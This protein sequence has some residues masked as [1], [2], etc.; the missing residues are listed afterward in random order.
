MALAS[1]HYAV[2]IT[3]S[4]SVHGIALRLALLL[5]LHLSPS[6]SFPQYLFLFLPFSL[7]P[8]RYYTKVSSP[9]SVPT[10]AVVTN[11][12]WQ[13][14]P[15]VVVC[16]YTYEESLLITTPR[17]CVPRSLTAAGAVLLVHRYCGLRGDGYVLVQVHSAPELAAGH[18]VGTVVISSRELYQ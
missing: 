2:C 14:L 16:V 10:A 6:F 15:A 12:I 11:A 3:T 4:S 13:V 8:S 17:T 1:P 18:A 5:I 7:S 9:K